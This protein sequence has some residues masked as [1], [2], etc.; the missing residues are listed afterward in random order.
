MF[1]GKAFGEQVV[2]VVRQYMASETAPLLARIAELE[3][4]HPERGEPGERGA[5]GADGRDADPISDE[6]IVTAVARYLAANPPP[7]GSDGR[8]G[9]DGRDGA[10]ADMDALKAHCEALIAALPKPENGKDGRDGVDGER[11]ADGRDGADGKD[12]VAGADGVGLAGAIID[13][14]G[15]LIITLTNGEAKALGA[16]VGRDGEAGKDGERGADGFSLEDFDV[17]LKA[18]GRTV[19]LSFSRGDETFTRELALPTMIYRGAY[20]DGKEYER[21]DTVT[22]AGSL[23]HCNGGETTGEWAGTT[24]DKPGEGS[25]A[26][27]LAAKRGRDGKDFAGPQEKPPAKVRV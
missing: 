13:R 8:H 1:D 6:Q 9:A 5:A 17:N 16:V 2:E 27:T 12:G 3:Q 21:G 19:E 24:K 10:D 23:W 25:K 26:W 11:G 4:R 15:G 7:A 20:V 22:W 14:D 18:D